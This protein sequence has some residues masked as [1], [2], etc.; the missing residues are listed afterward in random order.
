MA[1]VHHHTTVYLLLSLCCLIARVIHLSTG[2][3]NAKYLSQQRRDAVLTPDL[4]V[5]ALT[6]IMD[7]FVEYVNH[8]LKW[9]WEKCM[10][11]CVTEM[12]KKKTTPLKAGPP[13]LVETHV[14]HKHTHTHHID[15]A[16]YIFPYM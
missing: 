6:Q 16:I 11:V 9:L 12:L 2:L 7:Q 3:G 1:G 14:R 15:A 10:C 8:N 4:T 13:I 5:E